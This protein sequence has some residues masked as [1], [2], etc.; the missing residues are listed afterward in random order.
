MGHRRI[1]LGLSLCLL[2]LLGGR[3]RADDAQ[4]GLPLDLT[5]GQTQR[6][7]MGVHGA[8]ARMTLGDP[9]VL[10]V[11]PRERFQLDLHAVGAGQT[12]LQVWGADGSTR[13]Y[14]VRVR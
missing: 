11:L 4:E 12:V 7:D 5:V 6:V 14:R 8:I 1:A 13:S 2:T 10:E 3:V 9:R